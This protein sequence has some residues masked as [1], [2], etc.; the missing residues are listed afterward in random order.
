M[1][2][3]MLLKWASVAALVLSLLLC[4][5]VWACYAVQPDSCAGVTFWPV[6]FWAAVGVPFA[7]LCLRRGKRSA[8]GVLLLWLLC[9]A[10]VAEEPRSIARFRSLPD[11]GWQAARE[12]GKAVRVVSLNC[13]G[14]N[15]EAASEVA[16][17]HPDIVL[18]QESPDK[19][20]V[21][22]ISRRLFGKDGGV[23]AGLD[24]S[25]MVR[26]KLLATY[27]RAPGRI[28]SKRGAC[29]FTRVSA[30]L[31]SGREI[32][33]ISARLAPPVFRT[34]PWRRGYWRDYADKRRSQRE[35]V[36]EMVKG[37][38]A[39]PESRPV[40]LGGDFN[41]PAGD[42]ILRLLEPRLRDTFSEGGTG[43]GNTVVNELPISRFDQ[44]WASQDFRVVSVVARKTRH[45]DHRMVI[46]DLLLRRRP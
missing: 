25:V 31:L 12:H 26:G 14:G 34:D 33:V 23:F 20:T 10:V 38:E 43:W 19:G 30:R 8:A 36:R 7:A 44:I 1:L 45:S 35:Q 22:A 21:E 9:M 11:A 46:C 37:V 29:F 40:I 5:F 27:G 2:Y 6:W 41:A 24:A 17:Y 13:S 18:F 39:I 16:A 15:S 4:V 28:G 3:D 32:E 42:A